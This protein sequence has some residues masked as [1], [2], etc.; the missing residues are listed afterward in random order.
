MTLE[1]V[2]TT[3]APLST[4]VIVKRSEI[5]PGFPSPGSVGSP[6]FRADD[7]G[8]ANGTLLPADGDFGKRLD[9]AVQALRGG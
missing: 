9:A 1:A 6:G 5:L 3:Q 7:A 2:V 4:C 8:R